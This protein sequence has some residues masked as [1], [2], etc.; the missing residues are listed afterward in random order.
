[1]A[2]LSCSSSSALLA[3]RTLNFISEAEAP[4]ETISLPA[5]TLRSSG[6]E[7]L[8]SG[9]GSVNFE[10]IRQAL[11]EFFEAAAKEPFEFLTKAAPL[12]EVETLWDSAEAGTRLVFQP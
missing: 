8:G 7:L 1:M 4:G 10:Q 12:A 9:F 5:A 2:L 3:D 6:L 11:A